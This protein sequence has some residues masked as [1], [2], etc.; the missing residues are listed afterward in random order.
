MKTGLLDIDEV[1][2]RVISQS[3]YLNSFLGILAF[4][5]GLTCLNFPD[6]KLAAYTCLGVI[7]PLYVKA[8]SMTPSSI[9]ALRQL[10]KETKDPHAIEVL[11][12]LERNYVGFRV[13]L[14]RNIVFW[15][16]FGFFVVVAIAPE[17]IYWLRT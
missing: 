8:V 13:I 12:Y 3:E 4:T 5:L 11:K 6:P 10:V 1:K 14:T 7:V 17:W 9:L 2:Q 15:Y 16:G